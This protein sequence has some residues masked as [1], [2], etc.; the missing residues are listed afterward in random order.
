MIHRSQAVAS[1][2][3]L[4]GL[5]RYAAR[6]NI[7]SDTRNSLLHTYLETVEFFRPRSVCQTTGSGGKWW[8]QLSRVRTL[9]GAMKESCNDG[10]LLCQSTRWLVHWRGWLLLYVVAATVSTCR[11]WVQSDLTSSDMLPLT[12]AA[13]T[14]C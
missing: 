5:N 2:L 1:A 6:Q 12:Y 11:L 7:L 10:Y 14:A 3:Q 8:W 9:T 13:T 4:T